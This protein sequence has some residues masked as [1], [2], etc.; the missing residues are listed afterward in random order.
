MREYSLLA[1]PGLIPCLCNAFFGKNEEGAVYA[2]L[3]IVRF[4]FTIIATIVEFHLDADNRI[5][6]S[7][8]KKN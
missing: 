1:G 6:F 8:E 2:C 4:G 3:S 5:Y 7:T